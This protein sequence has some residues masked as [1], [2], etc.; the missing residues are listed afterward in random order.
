MH[1]AH[2]HA[3]GAIDHECAVIGHERH[4]AHEHVLLLDILHGFCAGILVD[5]EHDQPQLDLERC[6]IGHVALHALLDIVFRLLQLVADEFE[7]AC[8]VEV[9]DR[10]GRLKDPLEPFTILRLGLIAGVQEQVIRGFLNLDEVR[11]LQ[12][13]ADLAIIPAQTLLAK[14]GLCHVDLTFSCLTGLIRCRAQRC[15][16]SRGRSAIHSRPLSHQRPPDRANLA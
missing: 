15:G 9:L 14:V 2:N 16:L 8:L 5:I 4:I 10:K 7:H 3:L 11:H 1:L 13:F 12:H 6:C